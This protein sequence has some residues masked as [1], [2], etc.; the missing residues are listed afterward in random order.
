MK[1]RCAMCGRPTEPAVMIGA[2]AIGPTCARRAGLL[3][4]K[5]P[6]GSR[7]RFIGYKASPRIPELETIDMFEDM[8]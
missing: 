3:G 2:E 7:V 4:R 5:P 6:K 8:T 1:A